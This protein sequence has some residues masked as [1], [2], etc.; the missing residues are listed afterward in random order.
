MANNKLSGDIGEK[1]VCEKVPCPNC[2]KK[3]ILL[4]SGFPMY[5]VQCSRCL[6]R[7]QVKT[8][9]S[10]PRNT[11]L[12]AGWEIYEKVM[13]AGYLAPS[14]FINFKWDTKTGLNSEIRFYPFVPKRNIKKYQL[15]PT[16]RRANYKMFKYIELDEIPHFMLSSSFRPNN[17]FMQNL[18][19]K[20]K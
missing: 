7:A 8:V 12:G 16:A 11:I 6:F 14:L 17:L 10:P 9:N 19:R 13:K 2:G 1:E 15:S 20:H 3:L 18:R 5:D 4:P